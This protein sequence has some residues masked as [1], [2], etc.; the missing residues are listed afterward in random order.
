MASQ[1][2]IGEARPTAPGGARGGADGHRRHL[3]DR[4]SPAQRTALAIGVLLVTFAL[5]LHG[6]LRNQGPPM[7]EGFMLV[8]A[9]MVMNGKVPNRDFLHLYG[10]GSLWV[11]AAVFEVVGVSLTAERLVGLTQQVGLVLG[12]FAIARRWGRTVAVAC[13]VIS[14]MIII[15]PIGLTALAW[16]GGVALGLWAVHLGSLA[17]V[18]TDE[19][20]AGRAAVGAGL[21]AGA[22]LLYRPDLIVALAL[23]GAVILW[24]MRPRLVRRVLIGGAAGVSPYL[25]HLAMAGPGNAVRGMIIDPVFHLRGGRALP[26]PPSPRELQGF[27]QR[28]GDMEPFGWPLPM[29]PTPMQITLW[30][31]L[32]PLSVIALLAAGALLV[33]RRPGSPR[34]IALL[35]VAAF[36]LGMLPQAVQRADSTHL[37]WVSCVPMAFLPIAG[38]ELL[39]RLRPSLAPRRQGALAGGA[40]LVAVVLLL[41]AFTARSYSDAVAQTFGIHR[42]SFP[43]THEGR[44]FYYGRP[45]VARAL[46]PLLAE[47]ERITEP[48]DRLFVGTSDLRFTP[49]ND[50]FIYYLLPQLE[51]ATYYVELD[52]GVANAPGSGL[53]DDLASAD[54]VVLTRVWD[55]WDEPNDARI[56]GSDEPNRVLHDQFC[57][58]A[59]YADLYELLERCR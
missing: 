39:R 26:I 3:L 9:E 15:P 46:P 45:D 22:S 33:R 12:V 29:P 24:G 17:R 1:S 31:F 35:A 43:I 41:P 14:A 42:L 27:L 36:S 56:P 4:M 25:V 47:V 44:T 21:L 6:L 55:D 50:A 5:P 49:Y 54:V 52:P 16:V 23:G 19:R 7:E 13:G 2:T 58:V 53:A 8:F 34:A 11:L 59:V 30:F 37:A 57:T 18:T 38:V 32:L 48:G 28:A 10:P 20:W 51:V 40:V